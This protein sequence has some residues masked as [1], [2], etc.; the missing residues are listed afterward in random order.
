MKKHLCVTLSAALL[1]CC[2]QGLSAQDLE[3]GYFLG[4]N[5]YAFRLNPA[6]QSER[7]IFSIGLGQTGAG[8]W[9]NLGVSTLLY[10][11]S[12]GYLYTFMNDRVSSAEFM[13]KIGKVNHVDADVRLN[14]LTLGFWAGNRF[15]TLDFNV[16]S[17][18][19][20]TL[21]YDLFSFWKEGTDAKSNFDLS[22]M[23]FRSKNFVEAA[24]GWSKNYDN[25]FNV[26]F[27]IK[28]L[29]GAAEAEVLV[30][31]MKLAMSG[32][33]WEIQAQSVLNASSPSLRYS[34][35]ED[36]YL[37]PESI[38]F[39][40]GT[41]GPAGYGGAI[42]LGASWNLAAV[43]GLTQSASILD[44]GA[45]RWNREVKG[46]SPETSYSWEP[47]EEGEADDWEEEIGEAVSAL[48]GVFQFKES[49]NK[50]A[51]FEFL[52]L[53]YNLGAEYRM[54]FY[55]RLSVGALYSGRIGSGFARQS[56]RLSLNWNPLNF[57]SMST[58]STLSNLGESFG[59]AFNL[60][61]GFFNLMFGC[62][63]IPVHTVNIASLLEDADIPQQYK[64]YAV[65]PR[66]QMKLNF[67]IGLN[68]A[69]GR[70]HLEHDKR[71]IE[72]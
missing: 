58:S 44:F 14:L 26:G 25:V 64:R 24:F 45:M 32:Q 63:Y 21:P 34:L 43:P 62:D 71:F 40:E 36:G 59:F 39:N 46:V 53:Q 72:R 9:S 69:F 65:I 70:R 60:H 56:A 17:L 37:D 31:N 67:Y 10:P 57:L 55:Q 47:S 11:D 68:F 6:F 22:G 42:D 15:I 50:G 61:P 8:A 19:G 5:P 7:S 49:S 29:V 13:R 28:G 52:P 30:K 66:D 51:E 1:L 35:T 16:R 12:N 2:Q 27:R 41:Y 48:S 23:G 4:G 54:P 33:R 38:Y 20:T 3:T 18:N